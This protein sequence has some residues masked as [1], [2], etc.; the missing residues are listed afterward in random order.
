DLGELLETGLPEGVE[1][2]G[3]GGGRLDL[4]RVE[5]GGGELGL[6]ADGDGELEKAGLAEAFGKLV[7]LALL[8][9][10]FPLLDGLE[11]V[12]AEAEGAFGVLVGGDEERGLV[13]DAVGGIVA[14]AADRQ[15]AGEDVFLVDL[16]LVLSEQG[17]GEA[18][19]KRKAKPAARHVT[20]SCGKLLGR[21]R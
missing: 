17:E 16:V 19:E 6:L 21:G 5:G 9:G 2:L 12:V 3:H 10:D 13:A 20:N 7:G 4:G 14:T 1:V 15:T 18:K 11:A 8:D